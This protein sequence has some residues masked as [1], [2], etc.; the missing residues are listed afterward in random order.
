MPCKLVIIG[1]GLGGLEC[2]YLLARRGWQ[3]TVLERH[4]VAGGCL[5][6]FRRSNTTF[7]TGLHYV[8]GL[9]EGESLHALFDYFQL[10]DLPWRPLDRT[11][12]DEI[13]T[14]GRSFLLPNGYDAWCEHLTS[15]FPHEQQGINTLM[16]LFR[17]TEQ[18]LFSFL[19]PDSTE[20]QQTM[21][22]FGISASEW[23]EQTIHDPLLRS[24]LSGN[25][26]RIGLTEV[27]P[28]YAYAQIQGS[29][30]RSAW[31]LGGGG[32]QI[33][34]RLVAGIR[35]QGGQVLT[36]VEVTGLEETNGR[37]TAVKTAQGERYEA[38]AV[39]AA[40]HPQRL[41]PMLHDCPSV[42]KVYRH[43]VMQM[44]NTTGM[45]T[46]HM[47]LRPGS[48]PYLNRTVYI[49]GAQPLMIHS[50]PD[51]P[52]LDILTPSAWSEWE[53]WADQRDEAYEAYKQ[54]KA[55][56]CIRI[57]AQRLPDLPAAIE[58]VYTS[59]PL[60]YARYTGTV[61]GS[62]YGLKKDWHSPMTTL[63]ATRTPLPNLWLTG[64][65]NNL[66]GVL[67]VTMTALQTCNELTGESGWIEQII[68]H[69]R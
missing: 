39:I 62:A 49:T 37:I 31:R 54:R 17:Q 23:L 35:Q 44:K 56:E 47:A 26:L 1:A 41:M 24:V 50:Y 58:Q 67:G 3:V 8:G 21:Q 2:G 33:A 46:L 40:L 63:L 66:H 19:H 10:L 61:Q 15:S 48:L 52:A 4:A 57:A 13:V 27:T 28:L 25:G 59:T 29:Y 9:G 65:N 69:Q 43:R 36:D 20:H 45:F 55:E 12:Y 18:Y 5:Q 22:L 30:V 51:R 14:D 16:N 38:D 34:D 32:Q 42:R 6:T 11:G 60:T 7:D 68:Q 53:Q 64:Q